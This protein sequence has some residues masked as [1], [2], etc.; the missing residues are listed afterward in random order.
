MVIVF[1]D[2]AE[3]I[4]LD[5]MQ[6]GMTF[7]S[8]ACISALNKMRKRFQSVRPDKNQHEMLFQH[9][10]ARPHASVSDRK[11]ITQL[12]GWCYCIHPKA[13]AQYLQNFTSSGP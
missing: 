2:C 11:A 5:V 12:A 3:V 4:L 10:N 6:R 7:N 1:W 9:D 13:L 8:D